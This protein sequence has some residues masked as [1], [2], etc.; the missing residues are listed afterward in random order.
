MG[1]STLSS[2]NSAKFKQTCSPNPPGKPQFQQFGD[3]AMGFEV[4]SGEEAFGD[5]QAEAKSLVNRVVEL[6]LVEEVDSQLLGKDHASEQELMTQE[7]AP[8]FVPAGYVFALHLEFAG[9][10]VDPFEAEI[11]AA[12]STDIIDPLRPYAPNRFLTRIGAARPFE[13]AR[14][15]RV[16]AQPRLWRTFVH[17]FGPFLEVDA[18]RRIVGSQTHGGIIDALVGQGKSAVAHVVEIGT[19]SQIPMWI[20]PEMQG[21][22][23]RS[24]YIDPQRIGQVVGIGDRIVGIGLIGQSA[25]QPYA[26]IEAMFREK[27]RFHIPHRCGAISE[28]F[29]AVVPKSERGARPRITIAKIPSA[30]PDELFAN[31]HFG[32]P[33]KGMPHGI[34]CIRMNQH[35]AIMGPATENPSGFDAVGIFGQLAK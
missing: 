10:V 3:V 9:T 25:A 26:E 7:N 6:E 21:G 34:K 28:D 19:Q 33:R 11:E 27:D 13:R 12:P 4:E 24:R 18:L 15:A 23:D 20:Q 2:S 22:T 29:A 31:V 16:Q 17:V 8:A 35:K 30:F 32:T 1:E 5:M 14:H